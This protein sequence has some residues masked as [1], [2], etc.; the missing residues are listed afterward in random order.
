[1]AQLFESAVSLSISSLAP[2][3]QGTSNA[4]T[5]AKLFVFIPLSLELDLIGYGIDRKLRLPRAFDSMCS[6]PS[7]WEESRGG[8]GPEP[9]KVRIRRARSAARPRF[10]IYELSTWLCRARWRR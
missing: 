3:T 9:A 7:H 10:P 6:G 2:A 5:I 8:H 1:M 4:S